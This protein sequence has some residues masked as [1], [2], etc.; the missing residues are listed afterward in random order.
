MLES[1][2][3]TAQIVTLCTFVFFLAVN[4]FFLYIAFVCSNSRPYLPT[5]YLGNWDGY[6]PFTSLLIP[7]LIGMAIYHVYYF[8]EWLSIVL[9]C[10]K[11]GFDIYQEYLSFQLTFIV[12]QTNVLYVTVYAVITLLDAYSVIVY[13]TNTVSR[14]IYFCIFFGFPFVLY[15]LL[16]LISIHY[17]KHL[18]DNLSNTSYEQF[19]ISGSSQ[20]SIP[21]CQRNLSD[22]RKC[23]YFTKIGICKNQ[24]SWLKNLSTGIA[25]QCDL[26]LLLSVIQFTADSHY[27]PK[28]Y[29]L[30]I[31]IFSFFPSHSRLFNLFFSQ[32]LSFPSL[33]NS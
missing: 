16:N 15:I 24:N 3:Q 33:V 1:P 9:I 10:G 22:P 32:T 29:C 19:E 31:Q 25:E 5:S 30:L 6:K 23:K 11:I 13:L 8:Q 14:I 17:D 21:E 2:I 20:V 28:I 27:N 12:F 26:F 7:S 18:K 4:I